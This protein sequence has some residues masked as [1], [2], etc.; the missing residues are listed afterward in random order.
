MQTVCAKCSNR[1][2]AKKLKLEVWKKEEK[3]NF[4]GA[5]DKLVPLP[6]AE[7]RCVIASSAE[8]AG[9]AAKV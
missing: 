5:G 2:L 6:Q 4:M 7:L 1:N 8:P 9:R 3:A